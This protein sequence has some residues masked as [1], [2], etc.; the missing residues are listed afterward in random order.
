MP[1]PCLWPWF[2]PLTNT[3]DARGTHVAHRTGS[4]PNSHIRRTPHLTGPSSHG[5]WQAGAQAAEE[6]TIQDEIN[7]RISTPPTPA[8][9]SHA[10]RSNDTF[11]NSNL[12]PWEGPWEGPRAWEGSSPGHDRGHLS[13]P[14]APLGPAAR[15]QLPD[16]TECAGNVSLP[17]QLAA[18][19]QCSAVTSAG[20]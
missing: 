5:P 14:S 1:T 6:E 20:R 8:T 9:R 12:P 4:V 13:H 16:A 19:R 3:S 15:K 2:H 17:L 7:H 10:A 11:S 18:R